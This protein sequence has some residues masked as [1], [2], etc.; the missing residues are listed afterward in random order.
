MR[1]Y[2]CDSCKKEMEEKDKI[3]LCYYK[4]NKEENREYYDLCRNCYKAMKREIPKLL[5]WRN[6]LR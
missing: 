5:N 3:S 2:Y 6:R 1:K 4:N